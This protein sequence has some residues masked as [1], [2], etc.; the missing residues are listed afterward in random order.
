M[1]DKEGWSDM[2]PGDRVYHYMLNGSSLCK[3]VGFHSMHPDT[4]SKH[5]SGNE[6]GQ[7][8]CKPCFRGLIK[9]LAARQSKQGVD[10]A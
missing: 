9:R 3:K 4:L 6:P 5:S 1:E 2:R 8:D 7:R 10:K